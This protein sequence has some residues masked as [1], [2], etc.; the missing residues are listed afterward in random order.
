MESVAY[1][2]AFGHWQVQH[3]RL[4]CRL[5]RKTVAIRAPG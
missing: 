5:P 1:P 2:L 3:D 4:V